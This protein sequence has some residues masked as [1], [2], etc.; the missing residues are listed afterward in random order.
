MLDE[1][2]A[3]AD[4][5]NHEVKNFLFDSF[6]VYFFVVL[7][8]NDRISHLSNCAFDQELLARLL[9]LL[10]D[11]LAQDQL[12]TQI[13]TVRMTIPAFLHLLLICIK[14]VKLSSKFLLQDL[15]Y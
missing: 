14:F 8:K 10:H 11:P 4:I 13:L 6:L 5:P 2:K 12:A 1:C 3:R 15:N 7:V 9:V